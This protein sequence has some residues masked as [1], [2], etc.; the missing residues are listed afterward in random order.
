LKQA[1]AFFYQNK[2]E[3]TDSDKVDQIFMQAAQY[4]QSNNIDGMRDSLK[5]LFTYFPESSQASL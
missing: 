3:A 4:M 2:H 5:E 1:I